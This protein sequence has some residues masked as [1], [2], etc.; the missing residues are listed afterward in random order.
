MTT[1]F[2]QPIICPLTCTANGHHLVIEFT[3]GWFLGTVAC[4]D[5]REHMPSSGFGHYPLMYE[6]LSVFVLFDRTLTE[7]IIDNPGHLL[8]H[9]PQG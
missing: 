1:I 6:V 9:N 2:Q 8:W 5:G 4:W 3:T 7:G